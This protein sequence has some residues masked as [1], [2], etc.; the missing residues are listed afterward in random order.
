MGPDGPLYPGT[1]RDRDQS[2]IA[3]DAPAAIRLDCARAGKVAG[4][5]T[6]HDGEAG[7]VA[8]DPCLFGDVVVARRDIGTSYH[9]A[10]VIDDTFQ[11]V[12]LVTRGRDLLAAT[13]VQRFLQAVLGLPEPAYHHHGLIADEAGRRLAKRDDARSL[14]ALRE[15]GVSPAEARAR[16]GFPD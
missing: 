16:A 13:H 9:L 2:L 11:G 3:A 14:R 4:A 6:F 10:C 8:V 15:A 12:T 1:C 5:L 7:A